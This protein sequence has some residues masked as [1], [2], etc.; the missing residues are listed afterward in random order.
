[1]LYSQEADGK[2]VPLA[3]FQRACA[4]N[5]QLLSPFARI[6]GNGYDKAQVAICTVA[7]H[8]IHKQALSHHL[9]TPDS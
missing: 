5:P 6:F 4:K 2:G 7:P 9:T 1:M 8:H 3:A